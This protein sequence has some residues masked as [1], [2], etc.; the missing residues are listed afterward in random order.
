MLILFIFSAALAVPITV[1]AEGSVRGIFDALGKFRQESA[2]ESSEEEIKSNVRELKRAEGEINRE[3]AVKEQKFLE[4]SKE[5][6]LN[7]LERWMEYLNKINAEIVNFDQA[8]VASLEE[9]I[10]NEIIRIESKKEEISGIT[11][12]EQLRLSVSEIKERKQ[13]FML[14]FAEIRLK[15]GQNHLKMLETRLTKLN[16][17]LLKFEV[18]LNRFRDKGVDVSGAFTV[19]NRLKGELDQ[20]RIILSQAKESSDPQQL[21][22]LTGQLREIFKNVITELG[23]VMRELKAGAGES[24]IS[25]RPTR[26]PFPSAIPTVPVL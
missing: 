6:V 9:R 12:L 14:N 1:S 4:K 25:V 26:I 10:A 17:I 15:R 7:F 19:L 21:K 16:E 2:T 24:R 8:A 11:T 22:E 20:A 23:T 5:K 18:N 3:I 13:L